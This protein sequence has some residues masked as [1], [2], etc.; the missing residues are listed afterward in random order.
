MGVRIKL[1][2]Q[3]EEEFIDQP[4]QPVFMGI[5]NLASNDAK[6]ATIPEPDGSMVAVDIA[7]IQV[8]REVPDGYDEDDE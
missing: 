6:F 8:I 1:R 3:I 4:F 7:S 5:I 2:N